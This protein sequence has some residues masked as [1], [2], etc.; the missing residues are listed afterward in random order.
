[1]GASRDKLLD[2]GG[3]GHPEGHGHTGLMRQRSHCT[4]YA[5][6]CHRTTGSA[7]GDLA[8]PPPPPMTLGKKRSS[9]R[10]H[11]KGHS[12]VSFPSTKEAAGLQQ[13]Q[14]IRTGP[15]VVL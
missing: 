8:L 10:S 9:L 7:P 2:K 14:N 5:L 11:R 12:T 3:G 13:H 15:K 4:V 6:S 1:M